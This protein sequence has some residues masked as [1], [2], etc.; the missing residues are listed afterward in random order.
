MNDPRDPIP[1]GHGEGPVGAVP[2]AETLRLV[3]EDPPRPLL[4]EP[5]AYVL[6]VCPRC[7]YGHGPDEECPR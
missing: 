3:R 7:W 5:V 2:R 1:P 6:D 4:P